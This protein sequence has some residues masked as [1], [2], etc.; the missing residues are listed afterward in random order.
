MATYNGAKYIREQLDSLAAQTYLPCELVVTDDGST[1]RT[2]E[3][4]D[5]FATSAPFPVKIFENSVNLGYADNFMYAASLCVG[6]LISFCDQDD[7]WEPRKL[8]CVVK[9]FLYSEAMMVSHNAKLINGAGANIPNRYIFRHKKTKFKTEKA[10][11]GV[12]LGFTITFRNKIFSFFR[13]SAILKPGSDFKIAHDQFIYFL[14]CILGDVGVINSFLVNYRRHGANFSGSAEVEPSIGKLQSL[15]IAYNE[16]RRR[17]LM[18]NKLDWVDQD[19]RLRVRKAPLSTAK[20]LRCR[21]VLYQ[22]DL[23][24]RTGF[25]LI[26]KNIIFGVYKNSGDIG[27]GSKALVVDIIYLM[28]LFIQ[29]ILNIFLRYSGHFIKF[30]SG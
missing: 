17:C 15:S 30:R 8:H 12:Y 4:V 11:W 26:I 1:D 27:L 22:N 2:L 20:Y 9:M 16:L 6:T 14:C 23:S 21:I 25:K 3:I 5:E 28:V 7:I 13:P 18:I 19:I 10:Y 29:R 24:L